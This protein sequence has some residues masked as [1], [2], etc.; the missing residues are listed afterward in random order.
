M[1]IIVALDREGSVDHVVALDEL[2]VRFSVDHVILLV[3][4]SLEISGNVEVVAM[5]G[6]SPASS[7]RNSLSVSAVIV[8]SDV[9]S[10]SWR[11]VREIT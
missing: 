11:A 1:G 2:L 9:V 10:A 6:I 8:V 5:H 3:I 4:R 7:E